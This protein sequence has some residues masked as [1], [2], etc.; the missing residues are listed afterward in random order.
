[1]WWRVRRSW[2]DEIQEQGSVEQESHK[3]R[4]DRPHYFR[5]GVG[6]VGGPG[7]PSA[8]YRQRAGMGD[9]ARGKAAPARKAC[10]A[11][12]W[13]CDPR[14]VDSIRGRCGNCISFSTHG[15]F[16]PVSNGSGIART[17]AGDFWGGAGRRFSAVESV[18]EIWGSDFR[19]VL[20]VC[21]VLPRDEPAFAV[22]RPADG[23]RGGA[24]ADGVLGSA[25]YQCV[26]FAGWAG[27]AGGGIGA[28]FMPGGIYRIADHRK[29]TGGSCNHCAGGGDRGI[30]PL[31]L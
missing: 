7:P 21:Q 8:G 3:P 10:A 29:H 13:N 15:Y 6:S 23:E 14:I 2:R 17:D 9:G 20:A 22:W 4:N 31:Q 26:Q 18:Q 28:F 27:R 25:D 5:G 16:V 12:G 19:G 1:M 11:A 30:S 24:G